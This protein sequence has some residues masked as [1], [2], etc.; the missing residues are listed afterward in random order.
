MRRL[1]LQPREPKLPPH[2]HLVPDRDPRIRQPGHRHPHLPPLR[3]PQPLHHVRTERRTPRTRV[4]RVRPQQRESTL[5]LELPQHLDPVVELVVPQRRRL[6]PDRVHRPRHRVHR[7]PP[8]RDRIDPRV[9]VRQPR[10]WAV[11]PA[12]ISSVFPRPFSRRNRFPRAE[13]FASPTSL[14]CA[15]SYSLSVK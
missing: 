13:I 3:R 11:S 9:V 1:L 2:F 12:S 6:V 5:R 8:R 14:C 10:P 4:H 15:S 7:T